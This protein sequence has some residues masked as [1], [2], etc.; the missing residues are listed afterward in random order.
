MHAMLAVTRTVFR[1]VHHACGVGVGA[2]AQPEALPV[3]ACISCVYV[4]MR[5]HAV[6]R[7]EFYPER[8]TKI[9]IL[10]SRV[11]LVL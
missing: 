9:N 10:A 4:C 11:L 5:L 8:N 1:C 7:K 6:G 3:F 2:T